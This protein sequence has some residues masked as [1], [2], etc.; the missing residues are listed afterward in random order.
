MEPAA[1]SGMTDLIP[2]L[3]GA[4]MFI[5]LIVVWGGSTAW[6]VGDAEKRGYPAPAVFLLL[7]LCGPFGLLIWLFLRPTKLVER[8]VDGYA[9]ADDAVAAASRLDIL[10]DW[11]QAIAL[12]QYV[13]TQWPEHAG[14][15]SECI[16]AINDKRGA[17]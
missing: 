2:V 9:N 3:V 5:A 6:V 7:N 12:Y 4:G 17:H 1:A 13:A 14:Y 11:D 10:G 15:T 16:K 8:P